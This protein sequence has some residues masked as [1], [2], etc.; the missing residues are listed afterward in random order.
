M[1]L[2]HWIFICKHWCIK[3][4][5]SWNT[6]SPQA[7]A[8]I[9]GGDYLIQTALK[10]LQRHWNWSPCL[11]NVLRLEEFVCRRARSGWSSIQGGPRTLPQQTGGADGGQHLP[12]GYTSQVLRVMPVGTPTSRSLGAQQRRQ[13][14]LSGWEQPSPALMGLRQDLILQIALP[15]NF[16]HMLSSPL[17]MILGRE[18]CLIWPPHHSFTN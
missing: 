11:R 3:E 8:Q 5:S 12:C 6:P 10:L 2:F 1:N 13:E 15:K 17:K 7:G 16:S 4:N 9:F 14:S 18:Y